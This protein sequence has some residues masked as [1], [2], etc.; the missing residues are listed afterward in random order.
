MSLFEPPSVT[1]ARRAAHAPA[2][3]AR[4]AAPAA[5]LA[6][7]LLLAT[8][9]ATAPRSAAPS[10]PFVPKPAPRAAMPPALYVPN[11]GQAAAGVLFER[12]GADGMLPFSRREA[13]SGGVAIRFDGARAGVRVAGTRRL[14]GVVNVLRGE[15]S[16]WRTGLPIYAGVAYGGLYPGTD[17]RFDAD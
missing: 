7:A 12:R 8:G 11:A 15:R 2:S 13:A 4:T 1:P 10:F 14:A 17:V 9:V 6:A 3:L 5:L 16:A